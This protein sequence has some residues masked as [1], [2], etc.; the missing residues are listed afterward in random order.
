[1]PRCLDCLVAGSMQHVSNCAYPREI[2]NDKFQEIKPGSRKRLVYGIVH[3]QFWI[4]KMPV[5]QEML[6]AEGQG[7][8]DR[9][10]NEECDR[11]AR[12]AARGKVVMG[13]FVRCV[14]QTVLQKANS[15]E[16]GYREGRPGWKSGSARCGGDG[17]Q[18]EY[19]DP[20]QPDNEEEAWGATM[21]R[22]RICFREKI[23]RYD[24][25]S[26]KPT[27]PHAAALT[28]RSITEEA[29]WYGGATNAARA[30]VRLLSWPGDAGWG[31]P[32]H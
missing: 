24:E 29:S 7:E 6:V 26:H 3:I 4:A 16:D 1:M 14:Q 21:Q 2:E 19:C 18:T 25:L 5:M 13:C 17:E 20:H 23:G 22:S 10:R 30:R 8:A 12:S 15:E 11:Q 32:G 31:W 9:V 28:V 27:A